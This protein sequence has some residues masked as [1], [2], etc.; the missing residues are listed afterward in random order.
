MCG[1]G[2]RRVRFLRTRTT[3]G[4]HTPTHPHCTNCSRTSSKSIM[5]SSLLSN[6]SRARPKL[7]GNVGAPLLTTVHTCMNSSSS[8]APLPSWS[9]ESN[10][11]CNKNN[12]REHRPTCRGKQTR[13]HTVVP[14]TR[15]YARLRWRGT[16]VDSPPEIASNDSTPPSSKGAAPTP[17]IAA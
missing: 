13:E 8:R 5:P 15:R 1:G 10:T 3:H 4:Q 6:S 14:T 11:N 17:A 12:E 9:K 7:P 2:Q 16:E